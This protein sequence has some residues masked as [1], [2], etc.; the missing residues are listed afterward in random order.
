MASITRLA[1]L[2]ALCCVEAGAANIEVGPADDWRAAIAGL[3]PGDTL[4]MRAGTYPVSNFF[5]I[6]LVGTASQ[7]ITIRAVPGARPRI[8]QSGAQNVLN[9]VQANFL[10]IEGLEFS[11][12][13]A[14]GVRIAEG[15]DI[16]LRDLVVRDVP[17]TGIGAVVPGT[18]VSRLT[19]ESVE[20]RQA[21]RGIDLGCSNDGCRTVDAV[22]RRNW[23]HDLVD[24]P[25]QPSIGIRVLTGSTGAL[26]EDNVVHDVGLGLE[27]YSTLGNGSRHRVRRNAVWG[28]RDTPVQLVAH[29][30][31]ENNLV[32]ANPTA[33]A[34]A[35]VN[36]AVVQQATP[37][38]LSIV[39]NT[40][41]SP[42]AAAPALRLRNISG[43]ALIANNALFSEAGDAINL[44]GSTGVTI[45]SNA[46]EGRL[47]GLSTGFSSVS[48]PATQLAAS[49]YSGL[50][51]QDVQ[52]VA[53]SALVGAAAAASAP[54]QD[55]DAIPRDAAPDIGALERGGD[56]LARWT[57]TPGFK[58][59]ALVFRSGFEN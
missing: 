28:T 49:N 52:P 7:P 56:P 21:A 41:I 8:V 20:I 9:I 13:V 24:A 12:G 25:S 16:T 47:S 38:A 50:V 14:F 53:G 44:L 5:A 18:T 32:L 54:A 10:T 45:V 19:I 4:S 39:N 1:S 48:G 43:A 59:P 31:F 29:T 11:G 58:R 23:V 35:A 6:T 40:I 2:L 42:G 27:V 17:G 34:I 51:P 33:A 46:G 26:V 15:S 55:F 36:I 22:V 30:D 3:Q 57:P 37:T